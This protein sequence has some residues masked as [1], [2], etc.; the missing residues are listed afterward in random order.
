MPGSSRKEIHLIRKSCSDAGRIKKNAGLRSNRQLK[1]FVDGGNGA[2][3]VHPS[4]KKVALS[5]VGHVLHVQ[6]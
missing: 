3:F 5:E 1:K 4:V 6:L 2:A